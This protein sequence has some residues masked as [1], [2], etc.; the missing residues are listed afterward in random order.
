MD[1]IP[2]MSQNSQGL[3][4]FF[5]GVVLFLYVTKILEFGTSTLLLISAI[6]LMA[7]GFMKMNGIT[8]L[9]KLL[10]K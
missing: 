7:Y 1:Q 3:L 10:K 2:Q 6:A 8:K 9:K 5:F 4:L